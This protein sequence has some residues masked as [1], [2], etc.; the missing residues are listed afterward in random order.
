MQLFY[1][2]GSTSPLLTLPMGGAVGPMGPTG[3]MGLTGPQGP[4]G[5][6]GQAGAPGFADTYVCYF[7]TN[8]INATSGIS[9]SLNKMSNGSS[10]WT[11]CTGNQMYFQGGDAIQFQ[12]N[13][14]I[15]KA[16]SPWQSVIIADNDYPGARYFYSFVESFNATAG[17]ISL[18]VQNTPYAPVGLNGSYMYWNQFNSIAMNLGG[19]GSPGPAGPIGP[20]GIQGPA[21]NPN[22][23]F[24][25]S[26]SIN[27]SSQTSN[28]VNI[29]G[30]TYS[31]WVL[32][33]NNYGN[34]VNFLSADF[35]VGETVQLNITNNSSYSNTEYPLMAWTIDGN[36]GIHFPYGVSAPAPEPNT[37]SIYT[38]VRY[39]NDPIDDSPRIYCTYTLNYS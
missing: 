8:T 10:T 2:D 26:P 34:T 39:P 15:G 32:T 19:L 16:Y 17:S 4:N 23:I 6:A 28:T 30:N 14:L 37:T 38:F 35:A 12:H 22:P 20:Q 27:V 5:V 1:S 21:S 13:D 3:P 11:Y 31:A 36:P 7:A 33:F 29:N 18:L 9:P 24:T 25:M